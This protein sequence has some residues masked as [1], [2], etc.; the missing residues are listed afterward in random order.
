MFNETLFQCLFIF[1][2]SAAYTNSLKIVNGEN[3]LRERN[4]LHMLNRVLS[5]RVNE[6]KTNKNEVEKNERTKCSYKK[7]RD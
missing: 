1:Y 7:R 5:E 2:F 4:G 3:G 6:K